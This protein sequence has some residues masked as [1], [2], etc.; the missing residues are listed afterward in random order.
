[1]NLFAWASCHLT[2]TELA[3]LLL[4]DSWLVISSVISRV[5]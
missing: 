5:M 4:G 1:M 2:P 3:E